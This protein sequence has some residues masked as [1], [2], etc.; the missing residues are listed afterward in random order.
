MGDETKYKIQIKGTAYTFAPIPSEDISKVVTIISLSVTPEKTAKLLTRVL[1]A[2]A[3]PQQW[4]EITDLWLTDRATLRE[5]TIDIF[6]KI[7]K[8]QGKNAAPADDAE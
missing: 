2:S 7:L 8:R 4:D 1:A 5:I 6:E 3:G